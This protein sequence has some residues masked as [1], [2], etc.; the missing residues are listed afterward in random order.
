ICQA[1]GSDDTVARRYY[2]EGELA[3]GSSLFYA[4]DHLGS[5]R[6]VLSA[7][8]SVA[9]SYE[10]DS[11]G[12]PIQPGGPGGTDFRY[13]HM[14]YEQNS[15]LYLTRYRAYDPLTARWLSRDP[16]E[17]RAGV[18][19][20]SYALANPSNLIDPT[21]LCWKFWFGLV[22]VG[23]GVAN[24]ISGWALIGAGTVADATGAGAI[25]G[26]PLQ[27]IGAGQVSYGWVNFW[28]G[29][30]QSSDA[31]ANYN[32]PPPAVPNYN[33]PVPVTLG[34]QFSPEWLAANP[35]YQPVINVTPGVGR[36]IY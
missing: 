2:L 13:A 7:D 14:F 27:A 32:P 23:S 12:N 5:V 16:M 10:Y 24:M 30:I 1:R 29:I 31:W 36:A 35:W 8:G 4:Q 11:Y 33:T 17:E 22:R 15:G 9:A 3:P 28:G 18:N 21:G 25:F 19:L 6:D 20:Y 34:Y 26:I